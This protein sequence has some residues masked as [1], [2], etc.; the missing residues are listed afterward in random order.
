MASAGS[1]SIEVPSHQVRLP[2]GD[3]MDRICPGGAFGDTEEDVGLVTAKCPSCSQYFVY[4]FKKSAWIPEEIF[5]K[6]LRDHP[7]K[8]G[9]Q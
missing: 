9:N 2:N 8:I 3:T 1:F 5:E 6:D 4:S 7:P